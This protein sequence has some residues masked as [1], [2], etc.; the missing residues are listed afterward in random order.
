MDATGLEMISQV[1]EGLQASDRGR[2]RPSITIRI[3]FSGSAPT[4]GVGDRLLI[5]RASDVREDAFSV[6]D[7]R[8]GFLGHYTLDAANET[9]WGFLEAPELL[10]AEIIAVDEVSDGYAATILIQPI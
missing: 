6:Y 7:L 10:D 2:S 5:Q 1:V 8:G 9:F 4:V 3:N